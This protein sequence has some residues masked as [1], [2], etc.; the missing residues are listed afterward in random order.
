MRLPMGHNNPSL[1]T[2]TPLCA[3]SPT[4]TTISV[5]HISVLVYQ[6]TDSD[7]NEATVK[8]EA[9]YQHRKL[10]TDIT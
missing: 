6:Q 2:L 8:L 10:P 7:E 4:S 9:V 3:E 5:K 1:L